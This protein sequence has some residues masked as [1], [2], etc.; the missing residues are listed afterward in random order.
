MVFTIAKPCLTSTPCPVDPL[1]LVRIHLVVAICLISLHSIIL[2]QSEESRDIH[3][4]VQLLQMFLMLGNF[5]LQ[6]RQLLH[7]LLTHVVVLVRLLTP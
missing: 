3:M 2:S 1:F 5:C 6:R 7:L 4:L